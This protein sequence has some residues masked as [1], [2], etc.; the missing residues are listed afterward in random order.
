MYKKGPGARVGVPQSSPTVRYKHLS[1]HTDHAQPLIMSSP[2]PDSTPVVLVTGANTGLG[3]EIVR[4]LVKGDKAYHILLLSRDL[5]RGE[6]A[7]ASVSEEN[8][9]HSTVTPFQLDLEDEASI[10]KLYEYVE[11]QFGR[12]DVLINNAGESSVYSFIR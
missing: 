1:L 10:D 12:V 7:A 8:H 11:K 9:S 2:A 5:Q 3:L 6:T 4:S